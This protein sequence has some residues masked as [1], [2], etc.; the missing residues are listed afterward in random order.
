MILD[1][2]LTGILNTATAL[3]NLLPNWTVPTSFFNFFQFMGKGYATLNTYLP[4]DTAVEA[5]GLIMS[6]ELAYLLFKIIGWVFNLF[7]GRES[8]AVA[9]NNDSTIL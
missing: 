4:M 1:F 9:M 3:I 2:I 6:F 8:P 7:T 5:I